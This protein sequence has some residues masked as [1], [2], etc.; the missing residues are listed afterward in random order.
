MVVR[1]K[2]SKIPPRIP[3]LTDEQIEAATAEEIEKII[4]PINIRLNK[5]AN[6]LVDADK[7]IGLYLAILPRGIETD[8][9]KEAKEVKRLLMAEQAQLL[10]YFD[11]LRR[12][13]R[14]LA[15]WG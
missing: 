12:R 9:L 6:N 5:I 4:D 3:I 11:K 7:A 10:R 15:G 14:K 13:F 2:P 1:Y 8:Q